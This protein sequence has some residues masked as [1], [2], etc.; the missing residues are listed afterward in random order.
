MNDL[1]LRTALPGSDEYKESET[2]LVKFN[3]PKLG[4]RRI[5]AAGVVVEFDGKVWREPASGRVG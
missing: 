5:N 2:W 4:D 1:P 3:E